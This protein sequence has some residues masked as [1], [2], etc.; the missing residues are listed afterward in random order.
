MSDSWNTAPEGEP[1]AAA[2]PQ[3]PPPPPWSPWSASPASPPSPSTPSGMAQ[4]PP[5]MPPAPMPLPPRAPGAPPPAG[6]YA[7]APIGCQVCGRLPATNVK[8]VQNT[9]MVFARNSQTWD[10]VA[11]RDCGTHVYRKAQAHT[12]GFGWWGIISFLVNLV[13]VP[14][15]FLQSRRLR[16]LG[17]PV[18]TPVGRPLDPGRPVLLRPQLLG[19]LVLLGGFG[20][21]IYDG[22]T[23]T[24]IHH[25]ERGECFNVP[26]GATSEEIDLVP[27]DE[28]HDAEV[29]ET[30]P[31][32]SSSPEDSEK[33]ELRACAAIAEDALLDDVTQSLHVATFNSPTGFSS[34]CVL[35]EDGGGKLTGRVTKE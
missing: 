13:T 16:P 26:A 6:P 25:F 8:F 5:P 14:T 33:A 17:D 20:F 34:V 31:P 2:A 9:G 27:C 15:N 12:L 23:F 10:L 28:P 3:V 24:T 1:P 30:L 21:M 4:P 19:L 29:V 18:G 7:G 11:C 32:R 22:G 35:V